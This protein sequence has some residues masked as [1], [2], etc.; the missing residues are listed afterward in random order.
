[1]TLRKSHGHSSPLGGAAS[2]FHLSPSLS[3][4]PSSSTP[5]SSSFSFSASSSS[6]SSPSS[7]I[8][9]HHVCGLSFL[10]SDSVAPILQR[11]LPVRRSASAAIGAA[12]DA[13]GA[14]EDGSAGEEDPTP[15]PPA[16]AADKLARDVRSFETGTEPAAVHRRRLDTSP[17][18][19]VTF[20]TSGAYLVTKL[21]VYATFGIQFKVRQT[22]I[23]LSVLADITHA[24]LTCNKII[25]YARKIINRIGQSG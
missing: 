4:S 23:R 21:K 2:S 16:A 25:S 19:P 20:R 9:H 7:R 13:R 11:L 8:F 10:F 14:K 5:P 18:F 1:M 17:Q 22:T 6:F 24:T 12:D 15:P 3:L